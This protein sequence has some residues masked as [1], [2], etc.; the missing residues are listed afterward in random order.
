MIKL[1]A[2][3]NR[4]MGD[5]AVALKVAEYLSDRLEKQ[6][7][8]V[9]LGETDFDYCFSLLGKEDTVIIMDA[10][11]L[12]M[13]PGSVVFEHLEKIPDRYS[14][15]S[16]QHEISLFDLLMLYKKTRNIFLIGIEVYQIDFGLEMSVEIKEKFCEIC[17]RVDE[18][19]Q[20]IKFCDGFEKKAD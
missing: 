6:G 16:S 7:I 15:T 12:G 18:I 1:V 13:D 2:L 4:L 19:L 3:G 10:I 8:P 14:R 9:I 17:H 11:S 20:K 5:D